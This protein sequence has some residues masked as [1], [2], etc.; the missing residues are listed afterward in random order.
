MHHILR[1]IILSWQR[2]YASTIKVNL[3]S[4]CITFVPMY[5]Y[6]I[7][8]KFTEN[9]E[10]V[11]VEDYRFQVLK[12]VLH[13][14]IFCFCVSL[15]RISSFSFLFY[16]ITERC[17]RWFCLLK[18][19]FFCCKQVY[20]YICTMLDI[21]ITSILIHGLLAPKVQRQT[22]EPQKYMRNEIYIMHLKLL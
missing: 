22:H 16:S 7:N 10:L 18:Q 17:S 21:L 8:L 15:T 5:P 13:D 20:I 19:F 14:D 12:A 9:K 6:M 1:W 4:T 3:L 11:T 2:I